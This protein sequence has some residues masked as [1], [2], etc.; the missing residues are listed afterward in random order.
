MILLT[1]RTLAP[2]VNVVELT[3]R[4][5]LGN[6]LREAEDKIKT[7]LGEGSRKVIVDLSKTELTDSAGV[8]ML[9]M[10]TSTAAV[11]EGRLLIASANERV[12][13]IF[14]LTRVDQILALHGSVDDAA[15]A[16]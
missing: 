11:G 5:A 3:G 10:C 4:L 13:E 2:D 15:A 9:V 7:L 1:T 14:R 12:S 16:I 6:S 8:G